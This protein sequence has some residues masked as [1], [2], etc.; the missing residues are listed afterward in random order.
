MDETGQ[1]GVEVTAGGHGVSE[2]GGVTQ[3]DATPWS[4]A[5]PREPTQDSPAES[6]RRGGGPG[7][8]GPPTGPPAEA[9]QDR[10]ARRLPSYA[11]LFNLPPQPGAGATN[12]SAHEPTG[13]NG[14][15]LNGASMPRGSTN[16]TGYP[17][18]NPAQ[19]VN[20]AGYTDQ[21]FPGFAEH[22]APAAAEPAGRGFDERATMDQRFGASPAG[23]F[24]PAPGGAGGTPPAGVPAV[25]AGQAGTPQPAG[26]AGTPQPGGAQPGGGHDRDPRAGHYPPPGH[27][28]T[29]HD[30]SGQPYQSGGYPPV[31][32][33]EPRESPPGPPDVQRAQP[34]RYR[35]ASPTYGDQREAFAPG[36]ESG[37][38]SRYG[39]AGAAGEWSRGEE[40]APGWAPTSSPPLPPGYERVPVPRSAP[41]VEYGEPTDYREQS[42]AA[43]ASAPPRH[44]DPAAYPY[45]APPQYGDP[46]HYGD[47]ARRGG[48]QP[49]ERVG[50]YEAP[51]RAGGYEPPERA[52]GYEPAAYAAPPAPAGYPGQPW[53]QTGPADPGERTDRYGEPAADR[54]GGG[55]REPAAYGSAPAPAYPPASDHTGY[56]PD[57]FEAYRVAEPGGTEA[58]ADAERLNSWADVGRH[59]SDLPQRVPSEPDVPAV[60]GIDHVPSIDAPPAETPE[61]ARIA[62]YL[63]DE[64]EDAPNGPVRPDGFDIAAVLAAAR[65]VPGVREA[66]LRPSPGGVHTLRLELAD[67]ADP[68]SV[69][70]H[71][72]RL[73]NE[74]MGLAAEPHGASM[75]QPTEAAEAAEAVARRRPV[76][77]VRRSDPPRP[78][79]AAVASYQQAE[80]P[81]PL[82]GAPTGPRVVIDQVEVGTQGMD[83]LVEVRLTADGRQACGVASGPAFDGYVLRLAAV[84]AANAVDELLVEHDSQSRGR[85]FIEHAT[86]VPLGSCEVAVVVLLLVVG[87]WVEQLA[88][89]AVVASDPRQA[90]VRATLAAINRRLEA[91]LP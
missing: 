26:Q 36:A 28:P 78:A 86:V 90:V 67:D 30:R 88:G 85:C 6:W 35:P 21:P 79:Y 48:S 52:G 22:P 58:S 72:A 14:T 9:G 43:P 80:P 63:R 87:G 38:S 46:A 57:P 75:G 84:A 44:R 62:T 56:P 25:P 29:G 5:D 50:G 23:Y 19:P 7:G 53:Q 39:P 41:P 68:A 4:A 65:V 81:R 71:V 59:P 47:S 60:P 37:Y 91:L 27:E 83:A 74:T 15:A 45:P 12:G 31:Y 10:A 40:V 64:D 49:A 34:S 18:G 69:S 24:G 16:G 82:P 3:S 77:G 2:R 55:D 51:E 61:L 13:L 8:Y 42:A 73:L 76:S 33:G 11:D 70:R 17:G 66:I 89:S 1:P 32:P 20:G 54:R